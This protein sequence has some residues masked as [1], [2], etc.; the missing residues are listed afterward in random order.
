MYAAIFELSSWMGTINY[1]F[2]GETAG[3]L[4][5]RLEEVQDLNCLVRM[6]R[7]EEGK[8]GQAQLDRIDAIL[9]KRCDGELTLT[10]L[11]NFSFKLSVLSCR[12]LGTAEDA[13]SIAALK[14]KYPNAICRR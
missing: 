14:A 11:K 6:G 8:R 4:L 13:E 10:D 7:T 9:S 2:T 5:S 1:F 12:C 3:E